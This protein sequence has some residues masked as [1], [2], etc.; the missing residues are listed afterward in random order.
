[1][2]TSYIRRIV[3]CLL[4]CLML[5][6][7]VACAQTQGGEETTPAENAETK[8]P[9]AGASEEITESIYDENGYLK[10]SLDPALDFGNQEI[11][12]LHWNDA[13]FEE[14]SSPG[15]NGEIVNDALYKRNC[16]VEDRMN[17]RFKFAGDTYN[18]AP[19]AQK[20]SASIESGDR[21]YDIVGAYS[22]TAGLCAAQ[23]LYYDL[24]EVEHLDFDKPW[25]PDALNTECTIK[26]K[27][28][29]CSGDIATSLL[30]YMD[31]VF[32][33]KELYETYYL[34]QPTPMDMVEAN[35]WT[36]EKL[37]TLTNIV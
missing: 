12:V 31:A 26:N 11:C 25:W 24:A 27:L 16:N 6:P 19:F 37:F 1:M 20:L 34:D 3:C 9:I 22:Y 36:F 13:Y 8:S 33:N 32:Y 30:W 5:L 29:F 7:A 14:F 21:E 28:F 23:S 4:I 18:E 10:D 15:E 35:E 2:K 17:I